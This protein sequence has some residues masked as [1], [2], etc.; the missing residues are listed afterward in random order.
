[1]GVLRDSSFRYATTVKDL[2]IG[3]IPALWNILHNACHTYG[4]DIHALP[5]PFQLASSLLVLFINHVVCIKLNAQEL[6]VLARQTHQTIVAPLLLNTDLNRYIR[7]T[8][9]LLTLL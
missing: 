7:G 4:E 9:P 1:M 6:H 2:P 3:Q 8:P 5:L